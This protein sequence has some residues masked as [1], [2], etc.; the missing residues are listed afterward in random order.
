MLRVRTATAEVCHGNPAKTAVDRI[1]LMRRTLSTTA[2]QPWPSAKGMA[3]H[4]V[5]FDYVEGLG[6]R[7]WSMTRP[8]Q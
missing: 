3:L 5:A 2:P 4:I 6:R 8:W 1:T 7:A